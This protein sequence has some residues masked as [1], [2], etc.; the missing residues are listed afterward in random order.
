MQEESMSETTNKPLIPQRVILVG[1]EA[2][3]R[4][5]VEGLEDFHMQIFM[6]EPDPRKGPQERQHLVQ[7]L[8]AEDRVGFV[9]SAV[10]VRHEDPLRDLLGRWTKAVWKDFGEETGITPDS[11]DLLIE[12]MIKH[13]AEVVSACA[14]NL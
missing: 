2:I 1:E 5:I 7:Y 4:D 8:P 12:E 6:R 10:L 14:R 9:I 13:V 3:P 11:R